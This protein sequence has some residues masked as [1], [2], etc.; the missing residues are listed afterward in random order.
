VYD[1]FD[2][3]QKIYI[4]G[5]TRVMYKAKTKRKERKKQKLHQNHGGQCCYLKLSQQ[6]K[7]YHNPN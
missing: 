6:H 7:S 3:Q 4:I 5:N 2:Q 1:I